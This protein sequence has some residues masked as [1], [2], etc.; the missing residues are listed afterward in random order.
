MLENM[1][2]YQKLF[3]FF[4]DNKWKKNE[5]GGIRLAYP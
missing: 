3:R 5:A 4:Y 2:L 1:Y